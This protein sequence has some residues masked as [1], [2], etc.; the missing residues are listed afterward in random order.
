LILLLEFT[1]ENPQVTIAPGEQ[2]KMLFHELNCILYQWPN[3]F[4]SPFSTLRTRIEKTLR[5]RPKTCP[6]H[7]APVSEVDAMTVEK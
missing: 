2:V 5:T 7:P 1:K 3:I 6:V 4:S